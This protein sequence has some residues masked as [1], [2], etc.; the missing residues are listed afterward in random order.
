MTYL[1]DTHVWI[2]SLESADKLPAKVIHTL[3]DAD[4]L[5]FGLSAISLWEAAK[6]ECVG[7]LK[8][9]LPTRAWLTQSLREPFITLLPLSPD[10]AYEAN[11]LPGD[12][13]RDPADQIIVATARIHNQT[14]IT[15]DRRILNYP[16]VKTLWE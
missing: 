9:S 13:H 6:K 11:H 4:S 7:H 2:W 5:P 8:L 12:F 14:L 1:L 16:H 10:V 3:Y 15:C